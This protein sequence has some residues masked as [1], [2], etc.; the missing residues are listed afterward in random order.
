MSDKN[1]INKPILYPIRNKGSLSGNRIKESGIPS[2]INNPSLLKNITKQHF[3]RYI[4][5][6]VIGPQIDRPWLPVNYDL[7]GIVVLN[8]SPDETTVQAEYFKVFGVSMTLGILPGTLPDI[9]TSEGSADMLSMAIN[10][11]DSN[12]FSQTFLGLETYFKVKSTEDH[13]LGSAGRYKW[14]ITEESKDL[15]THGII[16]INSAADADLII[17]ARLADAHD[18]VMRGTFAPFNTDMDTIKTQITKLNAEIQE[19]FTSA[20]LSIGIEF[21]NTKLLPKSD[22]K[23]NKTTGKLVVTGQIKENQKNRLLEIFTSNNDRLQI[24]EL[25]QGPKLPAV[26]LR[27][28][29]VVAHIRKNRHD[30]DYKKKKHTQ[31]LAKYLKKDDDNRNLIGNKTIK[32][33]M[34]KFIHENKF[35][36]KIDVYEK[37]AEELATSISK[38]L[39]NYYRDNKNNQV[40]YMVPNAPESGSGI[41]YVDYWNP[42][43]Y[44]TLESLV[45][46]NSDAANIFRNMASNVYD[47]YDRILSQSPL[48]ERI[49]IDSDSIIP[50]K[51]IKAEARMPLRIAEDLNHMIN[52]YNMKIN[53]NEDITDLEEQLIK[54]IAVAEKTLA[55]KVEVKTFWETTILPLA[56]LMHN[57]II[58]PTYSGLVSSAIKDRPF[59]EKNIKDAFSGL[60]KLSTDQSSYFLASLNIQ[61]L[62]LINNIQGN[63]SITSDFNKQDHTTFFKPKRMIGY[64]DQN[65]RFFK[66]HGYGN[67]KVELLKGP[68]QWIAAMFLTSDEMSY[69]RKMGDLSIEDLAHIVR[70]SAAS[71]QYDSTYKYLM[72]YLTNVSAK[73]TLVHDANVGAVAV[74]DDHDF[75]NILMAADF[76][77]ICLRSKAVPLEKQIEIYEEILFKK[78]KDIDTNLQISNLIY[79]NLSDLNL[80]AVEIT[81]LKKETKEIDAFKTKLHESLEKLLTPF[82]VINRDKVLRYSDHRARMNI[83]IRQLIEVLTQEKKI[84]RENQYVKI[85]QPTFKG[86]KVNDMELTIIQKKALISELKDKGILNKDNSLK[87]KG[88]LFQPGTVFHLGKINAAAFHK[89]LRDELALENKVY[90]EDTTISSS[91]LLS[92]LKDAKF[93][94]KY[95]YVTAD[96]NKKATLSSLLDKIISKYHIPIKKQDSFKKQVSQ[97]LHDYSETKKLSSIEPLITSRLQNTDPIYKT[98]RENNHNLDQV[99]LYPKLAIAYIKNGFPAKA[100]ALLLGA[101]SINET[102]K[103]LFSENKPELKKASWTLL[104]AGKTILSQWANFYANHSYHQRWYLDML[105]S[106]SELLIKQSQPDQLIIIL[107]DILKVDKAHRTKDLEN[108]SQISIYK[109]DQQ[110]QV[111]DISK[112]IGT[113]HDELK[114]LMET[115]SGE[116]LD[117][118]KGEL[119]YILGK[120]LRE[121]AAGTRNPKTLAKGIH[122]FQKS[123]ELEQNSLNRS[124]QES[125]IVKNMAE[126]YTKLADFQQYNDINSDNASAFYKHVETGSDSEIPLYSAGKRLFAKLEG[127]ETTRT[128]EA[129]EHIRSTNKEINQEMQIL[130]NL[131]YIYWMFIK[132]IGESDGQYLNKIAEVVYDLI[133]VGKNPKFKDL[134]GFGETKLNGLGEAALVKVRAV[135]MLVFSLMKQ[136]QSDKALNLI[137]SASGVGIRLFKDNTK[138]LSKD[139]FDT[140]KNADPIKVTNNADGHIL[141]HRKTQTNEAKRLVTVNLQL[142]YNYDSTVVILDIPKEDV[143]SIDISNKNIKISYKN[144]DE[145]VI[146]VD[147]SKYFAI[148]GNDLIEKTDTYYKL[149]LNLR[150]IDLSD[151]DKENGYVSMKNIYDTNPL[152]V[153]LIL[154]TL[155]EL[156]SWSEFMSFGDKW[157]EQ[158]MTYLTHATQNQFRLNNIPALLA[159]ANLGIEGNSF[160]T[161]EKSDFYLQRAKDLENQYYNYIDQI[162]RHRLELKQDS[163]RYNLITLKHNTIGIKN[164]SNDQ[165]TNLSII[166]PQIHRDFIK[167]HE[168][169]SDD[170]VSLVYNYIMATRNYY[171]TLF[172]KSVILESGESIIKSKKHRYF[173]ESIDKYIRNKTEKIDMEKIPENL[174]TFMEVLIAN[175]DKIMSKMTLAK[176]GVNLD[177][178]TIDSAIY[179]ISVKNAKIFQ[180]EDIAV[181]LKSMKKRIEN[182]PK[183]TPVVKTR[184]VR[185]IE[186]TLSSNI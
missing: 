175:K 164:N 136:N 76:F 183:L 85:L 5:K 43:A 132:S 23:Y 25:V 1:S 135:Q 9:Y 166:E 155:S 86:L 119:S 117:G 126:A 19:A 142:V 59:L 102:G 146:P 111:F 133:G 124:L 148:H 184:F 60:D 24:N 37:R 137:E 64:E 141:M 49:R 114:L 27:T 94:D 32:N 108:H 87:A 34:L 15:R 145:Q 21:S 57:I 72:D 45:D 127:E 48:A 123:L 182:D 161:L 70:R 118:L 109:F 134:Y 12:L 33:L 163:V 26:T 16:D 167:F 51:L 61:A 98:I 69:E 29:N 41:A 103:A 90:P 154:G 165:Q 20:K 176:K 162:E 171:F 55:A 68:Q 157:K 99:T 38:H 180:K 181:E 18:K 35:M 174:Q 65:T 139:F 173:I 4:E 11:N 150:N 178:L 95:G 147:E 153:S 7:P 168:T 6:Y 129:F 101:G 120:L 104:T 47:L 128:Q 185:K 54:V 92:V 50:T 39:C 80:L 138:E 77:E 79:N 107:E 177:K 110:F 112:Q 159:L 116:A 74:Y 2:F 30:P 151:K 179:R 78:N 58:N 130:L 73:D 52:D 170:E 81:K 42:H 131:N 67:S 144:G 84:T 115:A 14:A 97:K 56:L 149:L 91:E 88:E 100:T 122:H 106:I 82:F 40:F 156:P 152:A 105:D 46:L 83:I 36:D 44:K 143:T 125:A 121:K 160:K 158:Y 53:G 172:S 62:Q 63:T 10:N 169:L 113:I 75:L 89:I 3:N 71:G 93:V 31:F 17:S 13:A 66:H 186:T 8:D 22:F 28:L 140:D 96:I